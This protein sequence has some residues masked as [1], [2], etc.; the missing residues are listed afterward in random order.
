MSQTSVKYPQTY[1]ANS[2]IRYNRGEK[3][4]TKLTEANIRKVFKKAKEKNQ[5]QRLSDTKVSGL[6]LEARA[7]GTGT[8]YYRYRDEDNK[9]R[10]LKVGKY[11]EVKINDAR[12]IAQ[13]IAS[14]VRKGEDPQQERS[15]QR[16]SYTFE[17]YFYEQYLS[18]SR[19]NKKSWA[20]EEKLLKGHVVPRIGSKKMAI[21]R[22]NDIQDIIDYMRSEEYQESSIKRTIAIVSNVFTKAIEDQ[23]PGVTQNPVRD[24]KKPKDDNKKERLLSKEE[25]E[26]LLR[27]ARK[28]P[29]QSVWVTPP[30]THATADLHIV[31]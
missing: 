3:M 21:I 13:D 23:V 31:P 6:L 14:R 15:T 20:T 27:A 16:S 22:K 5:T 17:E 26:K 4:A 24:V 12:S 29:S 30:S 28:A 18:H 9:I 25:I 2:E 10:H 8:Y 19:K 1:L 11:N 7:T